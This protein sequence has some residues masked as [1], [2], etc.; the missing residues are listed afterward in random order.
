MCP[1]L[2]LTEQQRMA[3]TILVLIKPEIV[4]IKLQLVP[5]LYSQ[6]RIKKLVAIRL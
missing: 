1:I 2:L 5:L 6:C 3:V 4:S